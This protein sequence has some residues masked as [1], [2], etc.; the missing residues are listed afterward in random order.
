MI[1]YTSM[2]H[3]LV[4]QT[5]IEDYGKQSIVNFNGVPL[6]IEQVNGSECRVMR[7]MSSNPSHYLDQGYQPGTMI[8]MR[9]TIG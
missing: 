8:S 4:F 2:P 3:E 5:P 7:V 6:L 9:P 1:L